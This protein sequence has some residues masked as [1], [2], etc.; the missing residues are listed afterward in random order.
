MR[1]QEPPDA[2]DADDAEDVEEVEDV[3][4]VEDAENPSRRCIAST[5]PST[6]STSSSPF[7]TVTF[8]NRRCTRSCRDVVNVLETPL[9][10]VSSVPGV[11]VWC[12]R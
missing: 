10:G 4:D 1:T 8:T 12:F 3:E 5:D 7:G 9:S 2:D 6:T 11:V